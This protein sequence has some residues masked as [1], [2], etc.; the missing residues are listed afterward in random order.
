MDEKTVNRI[1]ILIGAIVINLFAILFKKVF[2]DE[3][4][5]ATFVTGIILYLSLLFIC[6]F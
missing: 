2:G 1:G 4:R 3:F 6:V 5:F